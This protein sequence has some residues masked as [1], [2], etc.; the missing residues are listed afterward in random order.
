MEEKKRFDLHTHHYRC[1]HAV[2]TI[3]E[4]IVAA[5]EADLHVIGISDHM[6]HVYSEKD[7]LLPGITMPKSELQSYVAEVLQLKQQ[8]A[9]KID[10]LLG[11][12][13]DYFA[14]HKQAYREAL[15]LYPFDYIIGSVHFVEDESIFNEK[16]W[17]GLSTVEKT[18]VTDKYYKTI[19]GAVKSNMF[20][21]IGHLDAMKANYPE[22]SSLP[23]NELDKTL[24]V[25]GEYGVSMEVNTSGKT[26]K[27][28]GWYPSDDI[29]ERALF[30]GVD[31]TF[32]SD[33]HDPS[34]VGD[35]FT[36]VEEK[37]KEIGYRAWCYVKEKKKVYVPIM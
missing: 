34:R 22:F 8:Y 29:L 12:E 37:L 19:Q 3:E 28:G 36:L 20:Q 13:A 23:T 31:I 11:I 26:K 2:G 7:Q 16:R 9:G 24:Q 15:Q 17:E 6:P 33:A 32:G 18:I 10:V 1:G 30:Y 5:I 14:H 4:Y 21:V 25:I 35:D 27:V